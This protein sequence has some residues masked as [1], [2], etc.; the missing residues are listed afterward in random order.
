MRGLGMMLN[1]AFSS[2]RCT[3][4][5]KF[6]LSRCLDVHDRAFLV[7]AL[8]YQRMKQVKGVDRHARLQLP[9]ASV[10]ALNI[11]CRRAVPRASAVS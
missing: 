1:P 7:A 9:D 10:S 2:G 5:R 6:P 4:R 3:L 8:I 11:C